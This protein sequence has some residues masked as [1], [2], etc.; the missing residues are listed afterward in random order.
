MELLLLYLFIA[1]SVSFFC[2]LLEAV[3]LSVTPN[4]VDLQAQSGKRVGKWLK[5]YKENIDTPLAAILTLNTFAHTIG[6]AGVGAQSQAIWGKEILSVASAILTILILVF[7]EII[8]KTIGATYWKR[9]YGFTSWSVTILIYSPLY[10]FIWISKRITRIFRKGYQE[11]GISKEEFSAMARYGFVKGVFKKKESLV[12]ENL[13]RFDKIK[14]KDIMTPRVVSVIADEKIPI[15]TY[16]KELA[17]IPFSRI[18]VFRD[19]RENITG[20]VIKN[21]LLQKLLNQEGNQPI[22]NL[23]RP[24]PIVVENTSLSVLY[25][26]FMA[27]KEIIALVVDEYGGMS[28]IIT[29]EDLVETILGLEIVDESDNIQDLRKL[30]RENWEKRSRRLHFFKGN[31]IKKK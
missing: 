25:E 13:M 10:P 21:E 2:S 30:A 5:K 28:G 3:L 11:E 29:M 18:P 8:P 20:Y 27:E 12:I 7:S 22:G 26:R 6:A 23:K 4:F 15:K 19:N 9:L 17:N 16:S 24:I 31:P 14:V 1:L